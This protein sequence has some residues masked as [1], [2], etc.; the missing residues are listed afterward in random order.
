MTP[1]TDA[2]R[3]PSELNDA[4]IGE[5]QDWRGELLAR[6]F[7]S[8]LE[9]N[10]RRAIDFPEG[11]AIDAAALTARVRAAVALNKSSVGGKS[12]RAT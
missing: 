4:R 8:S 11:G 9:G 6:L 5:L 3:S 2:G 12:R 1:A 10:V 7:N